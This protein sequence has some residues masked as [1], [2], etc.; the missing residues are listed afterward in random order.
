MYLEEVVGKQLLKWIFKVKP[1]LAKL[2]Y[3][4]VIGRVSVPG[5][6]HPVL[7]FVDL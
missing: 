5:K 6:A 2:V 4:W 1:R 7:T 3:G